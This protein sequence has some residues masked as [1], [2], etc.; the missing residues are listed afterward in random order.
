MKVPVVVVG[1]GFSGSSTA[2]HLANLGIKTMVIERNETLGGYFPTLEMQ[3][4]TNSCGVCFMNPQYPSFC[5]YI[6]LEREE[7]IQTITGANIVQIKKIDV[8]YKVIYENKEGLYELETDAIVLASGYDTFDVKDKPELGGGIY[9]EVLPSIE[10]EKLIYKVRAGLE[11]ISAKKIAYIQCV[12]SRDL[13]ISRPYCSSFCC[14]FAIKQAMLLKDIDPEI[15]ISIFYMDIRA[16]GNGYERY[17]NEAKEKGIKFI[18]SAVA[19]VKKRPSTGKLELLYT[20][21]G[22]AYEETFDLVILSQGADFINRANKICKDLGLTI[23]YHGDGL[24]NREVLPNFFVTGSVFEPMDIPDSV[25]DGAYTASLLSERFTFEIKD[26]AAPIKI[27]SHK[28]RSLAIV[29]L[30]LPS[31]LFST[32]SDNFEG[33]INLKDLDELSFFITKKEID[34]LCL[35]CEDIRIIEEKLRNKDNFGIHKDS[36]IIIPSKSYNL[37]EEI[38]SALVRL[39]AVHRQKY[40][41]KKINNKVVVIGAGVAGLVSSIRLSRLGLPVVLVEKEESLGGR[42]KDLPSRKALI[43]ELIKTIDTEGKVEILKGFVP[44]NIEGRFGDFKLIVESEKEKRVIDCG[45]IIIA[46]GGKPRK[47][48]FPFEDN[49]KVFTHHDFEY[50]FDELIK[51]KNIVM[52]QCAGS[53]TKENPVCY[54]VCCYKSVENAIKIKETSSDVEIFILH[55]DIRTYGYKENLYRKARELG[56]HFVRFLEEPKISVNNDFVL[57]NLKEEGSGKDFNLKADFLVLATGIDTN[58]DTI[59]EVFGFELRDGFILPYNSKAA[60]TDIKNGIYSAGLSLNPLHTEDIIKQANA[61]ALRVAIRILRRENVAK[62]NRAFVNHKYCCGCE[63][64]VKAC[65]VSAR[66]LSQEEKIALVD[67]LLCE[68]CGTCAMVCA[69]KATQHKL[70][71]HKS[72]LRMIDYY[73]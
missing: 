18:R 70:Y 4:P 30:N 37:I 49:L 63:L 55:R 5:P 53:R 48:L 16:F 43:E 15:D 21:E 64:C 34:A 54:R 41:P 13:R 19:S 31:E 69:N 2:F 47:N 65:P 73:L 6:E 35:I 62:F 26:S 27:K 45:A 1:S 9:K 36:I 46:S 22:A 51:A 11:T 58:N 61:T 59:K 57:L 7:N 25:I 32:L 44:K 24:K 40:L 29:G 12:G 10:M 39:K 14:M 8:G 17:Y 52:L 66:Y 50:K 28:L 67:D 42:I 72:M 23:D 60:I 33:I 68:G 71:E 56:I 38:K 20:K 3:F